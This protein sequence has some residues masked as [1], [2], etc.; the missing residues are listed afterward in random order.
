VWV[1]V[2]FEKYLNCFLK[3][4][5]ILKGVIL[6][7]SFYIRPNVV[8]IARELLGKFLVTFFD[9]RY[10][11]GMI[12]ETEAYE[13]ATD[14]ASHAFGNRKTQRT[15][16]MFREGGVGYVYLCYGI[17]SMF[18]VVTNNYD[19]PHAVLIRGVIPVD[20]PEIMKERLGAK[21]VDHDSGIGPGKVSKILGIHFS[22]TGLPLTVESANQK[23]CCWVEDR[24]VVVSP[25]SIKITPRIGIAYAGEH[26][27][28]P[29]RFVF[30]T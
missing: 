20:G 1:K 3:M 19:I 26:A 22:H 28:L 30:T 8:Q 16:V 27:A 23:L 12:V 6:P 4:A 17:H 21:I 24:N 5:D 9:G 14:K 18:N 25:G 15:Q 2:C 29:Y 10:S 13:G 7:K 11:S